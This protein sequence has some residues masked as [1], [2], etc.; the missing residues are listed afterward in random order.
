[1]LVL[2]EKYVN[3]VSNQKLYPPIWR[4][5]TRVTRIAHTILVAEFLVKEWAEMFVGLSEA[6]FVDLAESFAFEKCVNHLKE[7]SLDSCGLLTQ[8]PACYMCLF[9]AQDRLCISVLGTR[10]LCHA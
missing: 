4:L 3:W 2:L 10:S 9:L 6:E 8:E 1:M 5:E 7:P